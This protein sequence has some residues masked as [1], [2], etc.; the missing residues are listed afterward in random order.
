MKLL[1]DDTI[2]F[3]GVGSEILKTLGRKK[4]NMLV[5]KFN[6]DIDVYVIPDN[7]IKYDLLIG[8]DF[9]RTVELRLVGN[10]V[11]ILPID[12]ENTE[13]ENI[14]EIFNIECEKILETELNLPVIDVAVYENTRE[15]VKEI[16]K[17]YVPSELKD[18][19]VKMTILVKDD[20]PV[21]QKIV[22]V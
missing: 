4:L 16:V 21:Y 9:L 18:V 22:C 17:E 5:D 14:P 3:R 6:Y 15:R 13:L 8:A 1:S 2:E 10:K 12:N 19:G 11:T 7:L 20:E